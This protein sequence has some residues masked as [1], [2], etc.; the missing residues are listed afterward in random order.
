MPLEECNICDGVGQVEGD[1][2]VR[3][4]HVCKGS[5]KRKNFNTKYP[6]SAQNVEDFVKF[7]S[8]SGGIQIL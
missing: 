5:G 6:F 2:Y 1:D 4:C 8:Q 3:E 7:L